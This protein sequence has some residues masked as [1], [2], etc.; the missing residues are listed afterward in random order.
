MGMKIRPAQQSDD[1]L[2]KAWIRAEGLDFTSLKW[3]R[4]LIAEMD[5]PDGIEVVGIGQ[6]KQ[7]RGCQELGSLVVKRGY[8]RQG[9]AAQLIAAL[10]ARADRPLHL[11]CASRLEKFYS[12][13]GY[14]TV[15]MWSAPPPL[16]LKLMFTLLFRVFGVRVLVMRKD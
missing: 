5:E 2:I 1:A 6:I 13:F 16:R 11:L 15:S 4:F 7:Y 12:Q 10:E 9:V 14:R 8:R 3:E